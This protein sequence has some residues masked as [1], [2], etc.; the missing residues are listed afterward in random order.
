VNRN[1]FKLDGYVGFGLQVRFQN[2]TVNSYGYNYES[3]MYMLNDNDNAT[4]LVPMLN[5]G[6]RIG[7]K[8]G[9]RKP[10]E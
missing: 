4:R 10:A 2:I 9:E 1:S 3:D 7:L 6:M 5:A 8:M